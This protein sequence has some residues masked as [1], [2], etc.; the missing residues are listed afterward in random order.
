MVCGKNKTSLR[1][2]I[3]VEPVLQK[4][5][6]LNVC[7]IKDIIMVCPGCKH[8]HWWR[9]TLTLLLALQCDT[10][11]VQQSHEVLLS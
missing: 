2:R 6:L 7:D 5:I 8:K 1:K 10:D 4:Y 11:S 9:G 3:L